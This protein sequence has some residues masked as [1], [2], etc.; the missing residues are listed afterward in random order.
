MQT[1]NNNFIGKTLGTCTLQ[2]LI[3]RG[4]MGAVYLARQSRPRRTVAVKVLLP[5]LVEQRPRNEF[6]AR[7]RR[8]ADAIAALDHVNIMPVYEYGE[9]EDSAYLVMPYVTGGTLRDV[10]EKR[11]PLPLQEVQTILDQAAAGLDSAHALGIIHRDLKPGN[12]LFHADGRLLLAD[13]GLAKVL[14]DVDDENKGRFLTS[15][16]TIVGT[17]E[18]LSP[19]QSA[20]SPV[21]QRSDI[22][23]LGIVV[24]HMLAGRVPFHG[25]SPVAVAIKHTLETPPPLRQFNPTIPANVEEVVSTAIAKAPEQRF[26]SAGAFARALRQ[27]IGA[28]PAPLTPPT[29]YALHT[30]GSPAAITPTDSQAKSEPVAATPETTDAVAYEVPPLVVEPGP[31]AEASAVPIELIET[32]AGDLHGA[33]T[34]AALRLSMDQDTGVSQEHIPTLL[35]HPDAGSTPIAPTLAIK[36]SDP[37]PLIKD[38]Q[39]FELVTRADTARIKEPPQVARQKRSG[40]QSVGMMLVGSLLTVLLLAG[41]F[42]AY[43]HFMTPSTTHSQPPQTNVNTHPQKVPTSAA[44]SVPSPGQTPTTAPQSLPPAQSGV[45]GIGSLLYGTT[46]P[47]QACDHAGGQWNAL[48]GT[49]VTCQATATK[50]ENSTGSANQITGTILNELPNNQPLPSDYVIQVQVNVGAAQQGQFGVFYRVQTGGQTGAYAFLIDQATKRWGGYKYDATGA[51]SLLTSGTFPL[52]AKLTGTLTLD[53]VVQGSNF[54]FYVNGVQEGLD[55]SGGQNSSGTVG[56]AADAGADVTF[57]NLAV[58]TYA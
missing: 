58:Y 26:S 5:D 39:R 4:G 22:Y 45:P 41:G 44:T 57:K 8:E 24:Y 50:I 3:G 47:G 23:S 37:V 21:D 6:L 54:S 25:T 31:V 49:Q 12:M 55:Y 19:E 18:Y 10:L 36:S 51:G 33:A 46:L 40:Y 27:A 1:N 13:F 29:P 17:P 30:E 53:V 56:L 9:Q 16:G 35:T 11:G 7:F 28:T 48:S 43:L 14:H 15:V 20:G 52:Q 32:H 2:R 42:M 34:E 38:G